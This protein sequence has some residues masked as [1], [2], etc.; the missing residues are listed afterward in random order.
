[1]E[2]LESIDSFCYDLVASMGFDDIENSTVLVK[3]K[4]SWN[5]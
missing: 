5:I 2:F 3:D 4:N 1:M